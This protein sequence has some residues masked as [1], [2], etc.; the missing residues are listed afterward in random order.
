MDRISAIQQS[1]K[2]PPARPTDVQPVNSKIQNVH[3][4]DVRRQ[5]MIQKVGILFGLT[6]I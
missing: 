5:K 4:Q 3:I 6:N 1:Q 2:I